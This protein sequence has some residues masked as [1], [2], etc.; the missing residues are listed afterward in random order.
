MQFFYFKIA[1]RTMLRTFG[2][3]AVSRHIYSSFDRLGIQ[4]FKSK[5]FKVSKKYSL[6]PAYHDDW[7]V[8]KRYKAQYLCNV[9][10]LVAVSVFIGS[11]ISTDLSKHYLF[12]FTET[13]HI[14]LLRHTSSFVISILV[15][16]ISAVCSCCSSIVQ[17]INVFDLV[18][19]GSHFLAC[20][21]D[22]KI[23][24]F[25]SSCKLFII[26]TQRNSNM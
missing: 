8:W 19:V 10:E 4:F 1:I 11:I 26:K 13:M 12:F 9:F 7:T 24:L 5:W 15:F 20:D 18:E 3:V 16:L 21:N 17:W 22:F 23:V 25:K 6:I 14:P 2:Y